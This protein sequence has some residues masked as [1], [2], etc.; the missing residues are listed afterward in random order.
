[1]QRKF[2]VETSL[3]ALSIFCDGKDSLIHP[4]PRIRDKLTQMM[5]LRFN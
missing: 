3:G 4:E 5:N 2:Q 1:M